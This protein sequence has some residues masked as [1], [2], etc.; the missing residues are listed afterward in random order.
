[1]D[2]G[3]CIKDSWEAIKRW[4]V[5]ILVGSFVIL[6]VNGVA[7]SLLTG[8]A[9]GGIATL[10]YKAF[11]G[12]EPEIGDVFKPFEKFVDYLLVFLCTLAGVIA[13]FIGYLV[14]WILFMFAPMAI[15]YKGVDWKTALIE[16]KDLVLANLGDVILLFL[17]VIGI[18]MIGMLLCVVGLFVTV[19]LT[20]LMTARAY[21]QLTGAAPPQA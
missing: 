10:G 4:P 15:A 16:S 21:Q 12:E 2:I 13:C 9:I 18:N 20:Y 14:T 7:Q 19:P 1:M 8:H 11:R 5:P 6:L 3:A 17:A